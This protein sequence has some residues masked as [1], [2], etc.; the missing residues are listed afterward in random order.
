[1]K[2]LLKKEFIVSK[3][4]VLNQ[5]IPLMIISILF[6]RVHNFS[7]ITVVIFSCMQVNS[8]EIDEH[9]VNSDIFMN[10]LPVTREKIIL[11]NSSFAP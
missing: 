11:S 7:I 6:M 3:Q 10:S 2:A 8:N 4:S 5:L 9:G 1:M